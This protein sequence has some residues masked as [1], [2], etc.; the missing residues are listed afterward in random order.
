VTNEHSGEEGLAE[1]L[2]KIRLDMKGEDRDE[3]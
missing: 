1:D 2:K 3:S